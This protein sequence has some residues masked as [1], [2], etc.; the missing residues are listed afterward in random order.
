[1]KVLVNDKAHQL[2]SNKLTELI[3]D[4]VKG[5]A[6]F[7]IAVNAQFIPRSNYDTIE[8]QD[9]DSVEILSPMQGG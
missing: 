1:M 7:A 9:G 6:P 5:D 8:L 4:L 2:S 3:N